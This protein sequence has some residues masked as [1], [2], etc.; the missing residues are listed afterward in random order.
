MRVM[1]QEVWREQETSETYSGQAPWLDL[2]KDLTLQP[3]VD[4]MFTIVIP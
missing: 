3:S 1:W 2:T 4:R